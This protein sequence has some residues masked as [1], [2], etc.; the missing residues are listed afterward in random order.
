MKKLSRIRVKSFA[1]FQ[2]ILFALLGVLAGILYSFG[3]L[4]IDLLVSLKL[5]TV[6][7]TPGFGSG[8]ILAFGALIGMPVVF[9]VSGFLAG[10]IEAMLYNLFAKWFGGLN[11]DFEYKD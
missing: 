8:T 4:I 2:A 9:A 7:D 6:E 10:L 3:G 11:I 1:F 5:V